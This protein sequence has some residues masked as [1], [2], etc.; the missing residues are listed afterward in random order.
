[1]SFIFIFVVS[2]SC[3]HVHVS[4]TCSCDS[5]VSVHLRNLVSLYMYF[6]LTLFFT[7][8]IL[9]LALKIVDASILFNFFHVFW[10]FPC[11]PVCIFSHKLYF[12]FFSVCFLYVLEV[13][14]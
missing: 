11:L 4:R 9:V 10:S 7:S 12:R 5:T 8:R 1:M 3:I 2:S 13:L 14:F 6:P